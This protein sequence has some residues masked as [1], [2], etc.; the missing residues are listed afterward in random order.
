MRFRDF[1]GKILPTTLSKVLV[2][3]ALGVFTGV[4][5]YLIYMSR[6]WG[7]AGNDPATCI[8]CH[9]MESYY[10]TWSRSSHGVH[11]TCNDCH[12]PHD[13]IFSKYYFKASDG[14]RHS[15]VFTMRDEP[16][17]IKAIPASLRVIYN[18]CVRCHG[19]MN[20]DMVKTGLLQGKQIT[21]D[22][23]FA[24]WD[25]HTEVPHGGSNS[26]STTPNALV[27]FPK[28]PVPDWIKKATK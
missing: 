23:S 17:S 12:V 10:A 4:G 19:P 20:E 5:V 28:S 8:N 7:Y 22:S 9:V 21:D 11:T 27:P 15:Y 2:I 16:Q 14:L 6:L 13:N 1:I 25:C 18:N 3:V 26:L 24:C